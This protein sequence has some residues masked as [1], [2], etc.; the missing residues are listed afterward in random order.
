MLPGK[1]NSHSFSSANNQV[2]P[3]NELKQQQTAAERSG[4]TLAPPRYRNRLTLGGYAQRYSST[5]HVWSAAMMEVIMSEVLREATERCKAEKKSTLTRLH[6][7][8]GIR[9]TPALAKLFANIDMHDVGV[10]EHVSPALLSKPK[11]RRRKKAK[12][13]E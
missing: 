3:K 4:L 5:V 6:V 2:M 10:A 11:P 12:K 7:N 13:A 1:C 8:S 9:E